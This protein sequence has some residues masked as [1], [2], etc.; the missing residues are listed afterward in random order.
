V[1]LYP[2]I[3]IRAG[4][5]VRLY[6]GDYGRE[7][8]Y[9]DDPVAQAGAF[10]SEGASWIH[11]VDLDAARSG[12]P[13]NREVVARIAEAVQVPVQTGGG[14]R[15]DDAADAL[16]E[17]GVKRVVVGTAATER[18]EWV[19]ALARRGTVAVGLDAN[20]TDIAIRG[21]TESS[22]LELVDYAKRFE[23]VGVEALIVTEIGR[24]GTLAGPDLEQLGAVL[25]ATDLALIASGGVG[26]LDD[27]C[28]LDA[29]RRGSRSLAGAICGRAIYEGKFTVREAVRQLAE[30]GGAS[31]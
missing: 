15:T 29:L 10:E 30:L 14:V 24:D 5:C 19:A 4:R 13:E 16:W 8:V 22:G 20:G 21:W 7:T 2:A 23:D 28:A 6:Q 1:D 12:V 26:S 31:S 27:L 18:P 11:V 25:E 17:A 9:G 3:D